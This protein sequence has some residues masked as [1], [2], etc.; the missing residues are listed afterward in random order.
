MVLAE[1]LTRVRHAD[2]E[3]LKRYRLLHHRVQQSAVVTSA[4]LGLGAAALVLLRSPRSRPAAGRLGFLAS[5]LPFG[6]EW[7]LKLGSRTRAG[8]ERPAPKG[9][10]GPAND[11]TR[12][13]AD[14]T[15]ISNSTDRRST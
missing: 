6:I 13:T 9:A 15:L 1:A 14:A 3:A 10:I 12:P 11:I 8:A 2:R 5:V 7:V 4:A